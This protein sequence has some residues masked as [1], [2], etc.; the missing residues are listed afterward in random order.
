LPSKVVVGAQ[1]GDEGKGKII[2]ILASRADVVVRS[3][4]GNN[5]GHTVENAGEVYKLHLIPSGILYSST[6]CLIGCGVV[7]DPK[8]ILEEIDGLEARGISCDN[9]RIDPRAHVIMP[10]HIE[11]DG[12]SEDARGGL[13]IGTTRRGIG[14]CYM[15]KAERCGL[16]IYDLVHPEI[17]AQKTKVV[18]ESKNKMIVNVYGAKALIV[19]KIIDEYNQ[20]GKRLLKYVADVSVLTFD[21]IKADK[22]VL[23]EGAQGAL[24]DLDLG[25]YPYV[26]SSHPTA[27]GFCTGT[28]IGPTCLNEIIGVAKAYTTRVGKGPFPTELLD[29]TGDLIRNRGFEF[30]TTTG[31]PRRTGWFDAV[32]LR[33]AVRINGLTA[34]ALNKLDTLSGIENLK[35]CTAYKLPDGSLINNF[36]PT[37][38]E[39]AECQPVYTDIKGFKGDFTGMRSFDELPQDAKDYVYAIEKLIDCRVSMVGV[40]P[41]RNQNLER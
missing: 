2:D 35:I 8:V 36:P 14:P 16:R 26:T 32:I 37:L 38:E 3:Q 31:R 39:L 33:H 15:D 9:L 21:A 22:S 34:I 27:G 23:F 5:A 41:G 30:G 6:P 20:Y 18:C 40:G 12:L 11:L 19:S 28:G 24:L 13:D 29:E 17:F 1:W 4:G 10:W 7:I 25:T